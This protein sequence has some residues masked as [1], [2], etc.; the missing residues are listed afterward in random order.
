MYVVGTAD[1]KGDEL[2]FLAAR[3]RA[4]G[5]TPAVVDVGIRAPTI[6]PDISAATVAAFGPPGLLQ[7]T[8]RGTAVAGMAAAFADFIVTRDDVA[9]I[10]E[11][12]AKS[13]VVS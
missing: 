7:G 2:A 11:M 13:F 12:G 1:T 9:G 4:A 6:V 5:A 10:I 8:D 3:I